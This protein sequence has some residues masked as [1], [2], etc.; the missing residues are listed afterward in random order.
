TSMA[1][2]SSG[3]VY[4]TGYSSVAGIE[5]DYTTIKYDPSG[6]QLWLK[7]YDGPGNAF[8]APSKVVVDSLGNAYVTGYSDNGVNYDYATVKYTAGGHQV[9]V[10]TYDGP[11]ADND[12]ASSLA[13]DPNGN[14]YVTGTSLN[15]P[16][17]AN[18]LATIKYVKADQAPVANAGEGQTVTAVHSGH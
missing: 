8:N 3:N 1:L 4:V 7:M 5:Y 6:A 9:W 14:V 13:V 11:L 2:D 17:G 12:L 15:D 10:I 16:S 18:A